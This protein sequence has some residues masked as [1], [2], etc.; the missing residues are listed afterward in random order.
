[1]T[2]IEAGII[3]PSTKQRLLELEE[4]K[5][6]LENEIARASIEQP[7]ISYD[8]ILYWLELLKNHAIHDEQ[9]GEKLL[10]IFISKIFLYDNHIK[11]I[12]RYTK[13]ENE[14]DIPMDFDEEF[15]KTGENTQFISTN[16]RSDLLPC[17]RLNKKTFLIFIRNV[18]C[19]LSDLLSCY[20][21]SE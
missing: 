3:T 10:E 11:I 8:Q 15:C 20:N 16:N 5:I 19:F 13:N 21:S 2:A 9:Y 4:R 18:F 6:Q 12:Y 7:L 1:M 14:I 17:T